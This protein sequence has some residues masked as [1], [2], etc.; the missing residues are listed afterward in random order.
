ML[1]WCLMYISNKH[2]KYI[3][4][5]HT[6]NDTA[7][8]CCYQ[9]VD[10]M[11]DVAGYHRRRRQGISSHAIDLAIPEYF[12]IVL[13]DVDHFAFLQ[14][15]LHAPGPPLCC[16]SLLRSR[17]SM[18]QSY[19]LTYRYRRQSSGKRWIDE[20]GSDAMSLIKIKCSAL[21][22]SAL[23]LITDILTKQSSLRVILSGIY[24]CCGPFC[25]R[26][27]NWMSAHHKCFVWRDVYALKC[28]QNHRSQAVALTLL[29][30]RES[31]IWQG[32]SFQVG[33]HP[34]RFHNTS[35]IFYPCDPSTHHPC[36]TDGL[37]LFLLQPMPT[38]QFNSS[39]PGLHGR[40]FGRRQ[41]QMHFLEWK[42]KNSDLNFIVP[43]S[44][45]Q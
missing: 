2:V 30:W 25:H 36:W 7:F 14:V 17:W 31:V 18:W 42:W 21:V 8:Y 35:H 24:A 20:P 9:I 12:G 32:T 15:E 29:C 33:F 22:M 38:E 40:H 23:E 1:I 19:D 34:N 3:S 27:G 13:Y 43:M 45:W 41:F 44:N 4:D 26:E 28:A 37:S 10:T 5:G 6:L 16:T 11:Y 39:L